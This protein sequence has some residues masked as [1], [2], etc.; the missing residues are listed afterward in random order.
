MHVHCCK[1]HMFTECC[2]V[3]CTRNSSEQNRPSPALLEL[4]NKGM[5]A[6]MEMKMCTPCQQVPDMDNM[7]ASLDDE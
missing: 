5:W 7:A 6:D 3:P 2:C 1:Q 4:P